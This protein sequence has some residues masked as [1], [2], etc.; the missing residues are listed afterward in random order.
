LSRYFEKEARALIDGFDLQ[1]TKSLVL[2]QGDLGSGKTTFTQTLLKEL[3]YDFLVQS[4][5]F[6]KVLEYEAE[7][8]GQV[9][10]I[11]GYR[12][13]DLADVEKLGLVENYLEAVLW[14]VEWP[15]LFLDYFAA[16]PERFKLLAFKKIIQVNFGLRKIEGISLISN[17]ASILE[18]KS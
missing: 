3:G 14:I 2:L 6:L 7:D 16:H 5:T 15:K 11:D 10:H 1:N 18:S 4:P 13:Q 8:F 9:L 17:F 12:L